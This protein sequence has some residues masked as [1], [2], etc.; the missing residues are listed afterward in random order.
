MSLNIKNEETV[1]LI[2]E[3]AHELHT[4]MTAAI[5]DAVSARLLE[6]RRQQPA[7]EAEAERLLAMWGELGELLGRDYLAQDFDDQLYDERGIPR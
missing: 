3:L 7:V 6:V 4:S 2:R 5:T 1:R